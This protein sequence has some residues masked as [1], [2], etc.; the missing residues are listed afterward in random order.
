MCWTLHDLLNP[1]KIFHFRTGILGRKCDNYFSI[2]VLD[3]WINIYS[4]NPIVSLK[5]ANNYNSPQD[6]V[7]LEHI[8]S[9]TSVQFVEPG[10]KS[11]S[12]TQISKY[13]SPE[14]RIEDDKISI[15]A[16]HISLK[17]LYRTTKLLECQYIYMDTKWIVLTY[18]F[19]RDSTAI[20]L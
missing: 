13:N 7:S 16:K 4:A 5:L 15:P 17:N 3:P 19:L 12:Y 9:D 8:P 2:D 18:I 6:Y 11:A 14:A 20:G 1:P 10:S